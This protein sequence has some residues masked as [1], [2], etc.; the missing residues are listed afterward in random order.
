MFPGVQADVQAKIRSLGK[1]TALGRYYI[2]VG[3]AVVVP[4]GLGGSMLVS[5]PT[6]FLP[7]DV[8]KTRNA[9]HS[10][11]AAL[12]AF[13]KQQGKSTVLVATGLCCGYGKMDPVVSAQQMRE[14][15]NDFIKGVAP[16]EIEHSTDPSVVM[17]RDRNDEQPKN[18]DNREIQFKITPSKRVHV[19]PGDVYVRPSG[20]PARPVLDAFFSLQSCITHFKVLETRQMPDRMGRPMIVFMTEERD[21]ELVAYQAVLGP[22]ETSIELR[23]TTS[24]VILASLPAFYVDDVDAI[25]YIE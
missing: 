10:F 22:D 20:L 21:S 16:S 13:R 17:T 24:R 18:F 19:K 15:F 25:V 4:V 6:M 23:S 8:S 3:S 14:A 12:M 11:M 5:A 7:H 2:P 1:Q 9:Y